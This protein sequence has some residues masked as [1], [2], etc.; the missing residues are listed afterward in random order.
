[1]RFVPVTGE[2]WDG[3]A[4]AVEP[5][6]ADEEQD[7]HESE[8]LEELADD[9]FRRDDRHVTFEC[10][11]STFRSLRKRSLTCCK[12]C[13]GKSFTFRCFGRLSSSVSSFFCY[14]SSDQ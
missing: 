4:S 14:V 9:H 7:V 8:E 1:M 3:L 2:G 6:R 12:I 10:S 5:E 11:C 13:R